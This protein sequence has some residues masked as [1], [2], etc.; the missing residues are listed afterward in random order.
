MQRSQM[1]QRGWTKWSR[2][3]ILVWMKWES[4]STTLLGSC[5]RWTLCT[6]SRS[7]VVARDSRECREEGKLEKETP[8]RPSS[9]SRRRSA[10][11]RTRAFS[12]CKLQPCTHQTL[13][14]FE[15]Q[16]DQK[17]QD[18]CI[19]WTVA[20]LEYIPPTVAKANETLTGFLSLLSAAPT[21]TPEQFPIETPHGLEPK[22]LN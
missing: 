6:T 9:M 11:R 18:F 5:S 13:Q 4:C 8:A 21:L 7:E 10:S 2:W 22:I 19:C 16:P 17:C 12:S 15:E 20:V 1:F 3:E 14:Y